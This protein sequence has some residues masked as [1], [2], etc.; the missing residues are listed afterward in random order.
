[1]ANIVDLDLKIVKRI[2]LTE[3]T[4]IAE[5]IVIILIDI[6][7]TG[8]VN[9]IE[10]RTEKRKKIKKLTSFYPPK[11]PCR[12]KYPC[13]LFLESDENERDQDPHSTITA[14]TKTT[15]RVSFGIRFPGC[16]E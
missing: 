3:T 14:G 5:I 13:L 6:G 7:R 10:R 15:T 2:S 4:K 9:N 1:M 8:T 11:S 12:F 16:Q